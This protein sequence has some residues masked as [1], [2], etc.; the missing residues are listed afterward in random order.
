LADAAAKVRFENQ[1]SIRPE[2]TKTI[3]LRETFPG[4]Y[5]IV[6]RQRKAITFHVQ[7]W[8][9]TKLTLIATLP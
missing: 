5:L 4:D 9:K 1:A 3:A 7:G 6:S 8:N 2:S